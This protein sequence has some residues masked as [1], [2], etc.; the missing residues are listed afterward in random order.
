MSSRSGSA[1]KRQPI[2]EINVVP[3][4]DV[5]LV[6]LVIFM[7]VAPVLT[8]GVTVDLPPA[9]A[10]PIDPED[11]ED[12]LIVTIRADGAIF[13]N[14][15]EGSID[16]LGTRVSLDTLGEQSRKVIAARADIPVLV[17]GDTTIAYGKV[18]EVMGTLQKAG[19]ASVGLITEPPDPTEL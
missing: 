7:V 19:A 1:R 17:K 15:G 12:P 13:L 5:M 3:Y 10:E 4:I 6:L 11:L 14:L 18:I 8:Q 9:T 2:A 16:E